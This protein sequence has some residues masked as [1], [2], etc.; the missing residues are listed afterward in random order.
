MFSIDA[1]ERFTVRLVMLTGLI[2]LGFIGDGSVSLV[3]GQAGYIEEVRSLDTN[4]AGLLNPAGLAY[5]FEA[6]LFYII[7]A[8][9]GSPA[10]INMM[11][12]FEELLGSMT[13]NTSAT[14]EPI[15]IAFDNQN[16]RLLLLDHAANELITIKAGPNGLLDPAATALTRFQVGALGLQQ[17]SGMT[18]DPGNGVLFILDNAPDG[19]TSQ[20]LRI[21]PDSQGGFD[22]ATAINE[23]RVSRIDLQAAGLV[24]GRGLALNPSNEHLYGFKPADGKI[25]ELS[26]SG[27]LIATLDL[28]PFDLADPQGLVFGLSGDLTDDP[29]LIN[30]YVADP[31]LVTEAQA[32]PGLAIYLPVVLKKSNPKENRNDE[33]QQN[34]AAPPLGR[35][36][37]F[38]LSGELMNTIRV[39]QDQPTIQAGLD[40][41][42]DGDLVLVSPG[43][44]AEQLVMSA[45][46]VTLASEF[47]TTGDV[48]DIDQTIIDGQGGPAVIEVAKSVG[49]ETK[50]TGFT[51][52]NGSDGISASAKLHILNNRF[53]GNGDAIDYQSGGGICRNNVFE[54][55]KDDA[56]DL[57]GPTEAIIENNVI[58]N[59]GDDGIEIRLHKYSGP[60][61][62][63]IIR[64]NLITDNDEDG[65]Q[66]IDYEDLSDRTFL[67]ERNLIKNNRKVGLGLMDKGDTKEDFRAASIPERIHLFN[68]TFIDNPYAVTGGDNLIALHNLLV[69]ATVTALKDVDGDSVTAYNLFW[70]NHTDSQG[71]KIDTNTTLFTDPLLDGTDQL[72]SGSPAID[73]GTAQYRL[74]GSEIVLDLPPGAYLGP[75]PDLGAFE[76]MSTGEPKPAVLVGTGDIARCSYDEDQATA[77]LLDKIP[78]I[79]FTLGDHAYPDGSDDE[80]NDCYDPTWGRHQARTRPTPGNHDYHT[81]G[82]AGY[83][84]Y[85]GAAAGERGKGYYSYNHGAWH[86]IALN[87]ECQ[88][89][90]GCERDSP[91]GQWLQADLAANP[92]ICTLAYWHKPRFSSGR[93]GG[94]STVQDFWE[95]LYEAGAEVVLSSHDHNYERF[96]PQD[97]DGVAD[98]DRGI[99][100]FVVGTGGAGLYAFDSI[101]P[102][103]EARNNDTHGVLKLTLHPTGY[104][105]EFVP[106]AGQ[107]FT[108]WGSASCS[109]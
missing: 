94:S 47:Y 97:P 36:V 49:P 32:E 103:S 42:Q 40:A 86:I 24:Q 83:F 57:D 51:I 52:Q 69:N 72:Q 9:P 26:D 74:A 55:N 17:P 53:T 6:N 81:P 27:Q 63:I 80:F 105:W 89:V 78:G 5:S 92:G 108:D 39:P 35:I 85:F 93:H 25:Y 79:V 65:I 66:L 101:Q 16:E 84:N 1:A 68:N 23:G 8:N 4:D 10:T 56:I 18:V 99:R 50:I 20:I 29:E 21:E 102:N 43:T 13:V 54:N 62:N 71:S 15:N 104:D 96:A 2:T 30:L 106:V 11:T 41:A 12:P 22:G 59:N 107:S 87:S 98:P 82:A 73:A 33:I 75:A 91:Q 90:G 37:E 3:Q 45:K 109:H 19:A 77:K 100:Q 44:Y 76:W 46:T 38:T 88:A 61:L 64:H 95:L 67:I 7:T 31:G 70:G 48:N 14:V 34:Q 28:A 60:R 58:R